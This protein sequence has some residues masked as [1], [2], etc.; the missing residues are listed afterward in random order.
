LTNIF[1]NSYK[2]LAG[3]I[4]KVLKIL[5]NVNLDRVENL[6]NLKIAGKDLSE[7]VIYVM[8]LLYTVGFSYFTILKHNAFRSY[9]W[10]LGIFLQS[11]STTLNNGKF[12]Y[13]TIEMPVIQSGCYFGMHFSP[14][15]F[16]LLPIYA[17]YQGPE[18][19]LI[20]QSFIIALAS[21]PLYFFTRDTVK[22]K[23]VAVGFSIA[24]LLY[25]PLHGA[26]WF[27]F[28]LQS[29][30]PLFLF[31]SVYF[32]KHEKWTK[33]FIFIVLAL[34]IAENVSLVVLFLGLYEVFKYR[35]LFLKVLKEKRLRDKKVF[36]PLTTIGLA[37]VWIISARWI[38]STFFP[39][40]QAYS[41]LYKAEHYWTILGIKGDPITMPIYLLLNPIKTLQALSYDAYLKLL[42]FIILF[43]PLLFLSFRSSILLVASPSII[44]AFLSNH[45]AFYLVGAHYPLY[46]L[47]F[48]FLAAVEGMKK[49]S[50][51]SNASPVVRDNQKVKNMLILVIALSLFASPLSP[52]LFTSAVKIPHFSEYAFPKIGEHELA[53]KEI[54]TF[55]PSNASVLTQNNLFPHF[56]NRLNA[57]AYPLPFL[58]E[59]AQEETDEYVEQLINKSDYIL[60]D[61]YF[62]EWTAKAMII[63]TLSHYPSFRLIKYFDGIYLY[64]KR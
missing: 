37:L 20:L 25:A 49:L 6:L 22:N 11:F 35:A 48:I 23:L 53:L 45:Q 60:A 14:I 50:D 43:G 41:T 63:K 54:I 5:K 9:A 44:P 7:I 13:T 34:S 52:L 36:V 61:T 1:L 62:D 27:D 40:N 59:H 2:I 51:Q 17:I 57:Y 21:L 47:P 64:E 16:L 8:I 28:H 24:Y 29:F 31:S 46:Y 58:F 55:I 30:I 3:V 18:S 10:D 39:I 56:A 15:L 26:N 42:F 38:Q 19:I 4:K 32:L 33:Y 12:F